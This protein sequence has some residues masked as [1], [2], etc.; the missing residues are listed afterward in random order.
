MM[1]KMFYY[2]NV[3]LMTILELISVIVMFF[4]HCLKLVCVFFFKFYVIHIGFRN[5]LQV[6]LNVLKKEKYAYELFSFP[7]DPNFN[8]TWQASQI[9]SWH[10]G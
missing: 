1:S 3:R 6:W 9:I 8:Y 4:V 7:G 5:E 10:I 2:A